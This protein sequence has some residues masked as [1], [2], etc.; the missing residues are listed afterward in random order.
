M[1]YTALN[2]LRYLNNFLL[3]VYRWRKNK[4]Y[5]LHELNLLVNKRSSQIAVQSEWKSTFF[6]TYIKFSDK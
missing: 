6:V 3:N 4:F 5:K 2:Y 1:N